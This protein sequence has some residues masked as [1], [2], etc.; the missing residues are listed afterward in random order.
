MPCSCSN[1]RRA[2]TRR[3]PRV[4]LAA[5]ATAA[6]ALLG[7]LSPTAASA[8]DLE[9]TRMLS[10][11]V[12]SAE[13][14]AFTYAGDLWIAKI[15]GFKVGPTR[16]LTSHIGREFNPR[17]SPD[18]K[19]L[20]FSAEY[21]GNID[22]Y[23]VPVE[24]GVPERLTWHPGPDITQGFRDDSKVLFTSP[25][26]D[27]SF[28]Y[29]HLYEIGLTGGFP[30][31]LPLPSVGFADMA[32]D[33]RIAYNPLGPA[34][35]QWKNYRGGQTSR[36]WIYQPDDASVSE[37][38]QPEGRANDTEP[39][40]LDGK[41]YLRSD[42]NGEFNLYR[43]DPQT[44]ALDQLT[45]HD[46]F[47][48]LGASAGGGRIVY[49]QAGYLHVLEPASG[50]AERLRVG[51][52]A[53]LIETRP[54]WA[55]GDEHI[56]SYALS[57][58]G[59]RAVFAYRGE[60]VTVPESKGNPRALTATPGAHER[61]PVWSPDGASIAYFSDASGEYALHVAPQD[62][63]GEPKAYELPGAGF[64][65]NPKFSP[66]GAYV[67]YLDNSW[68]VYIL[69]LESGESRK[70]AQEP[71]YGPL[72]TQHHAWS[73]D[74]R[75]LAYTLNTRSYFQ[76]VHLYS[77][78]NQK[79]HAI[80]EGLSDVSEPVFDAS[81]KYLYFA[82]STDAGPVRS[83]FAMSNADMEIT[84]SL[85]LAVLSADEPSPLL[86]ESDEETP[87][88][89][90]ESGEEEAEDDGGEESEDDDAIAVDIEGL[91]QRILALPLPESFYTN[92][93]PGSEGQ[94]LFLDSPE[95]IRGPGTGT[96]KRFD[97]ESRKAETLAE[98]VFGFVISHDHSKVL[99]A[100][101][102]GY[103]ISAAA[104][105]DLAKDK[106]HT[107]KIRVRI[108]PR[109]EWTQIF[110]EAWRINRDFFYD[111]GMHGADWPAMREKYAAFLPHLSSRDDLNR[112]IRWMCS[113]LAVG[114]HRV[115]GGDRRDS[116]E[117][118][119]GGVLGAD[120][121]IAQNRYRFAK[122]L[123]GLNWNPTLRAPLTEP[124]VDVRAGEFLL[125]VDGIP[126]EASENVYSRFENTAGR[127]V[128]L[129]VGPN[130]DGSDSRRVTVVPIQSDRGLRNRD[131]IEGNIR[132]VHEATDGRVAYVHVP[133][134]TTAGHAYFKRYFFPQANK[135]A[136]IVDERHN[137]G[138]QVADY[139]IDILRRPYISSWTTRYGEDLHTPQAAIHGPK[140][141]LID[142][143]AGSGGDLLPWMFRK[144]ELGTLIGRRT[145]G[146]LVGILGFPILMDGGGVTAP[147]LGFWTEDGF[148]VENEGVPPD[149]EVEQWPADVAAGRD[150]Q[151]EKAIEVVL[152]QLE[153][154]P[155]VERK[156]PPFPIRARQ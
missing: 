92:L 56:R 63:R 11:P 2:P 25:R 23:A 80:T 62:G 149:I 121:E 8:V 14:L 20:A 144:L 82:A 59:A 1:F 31:R 112:V 54:R 52:A 97:L 27:Y 156:R 3:G 103:A 107:D 153:A 134:T 71:V 129:T 57:P 24:G 122:V 43:F 88:A 28:R 95:G 151:L 51:V 9:D 130:A 99:A 75:W 84:Q 93:L 150:P 154:N 48:V 127:Q 91:D 124:G 15:D 16:R 139:Y 70:I 74:S 111:P 106:I 123:G 19:T 138:G 50:Q 133:N 83:W 49:R 147:N 101:P 67:S 132:K 42:R 155:P 78:E 141:M 58:S 37:I 29:F 36:V 146:G 46:D 76:Q 135:D 143:T 61:E 125:A 18:G 69:D 90:G 118:V 6:A 33:G 108:D 44:E 53:D 38:E 148:R 94:L 98:G 10:Q 47:P 140:V 89:D 128:E 137:G 126:L 68:S 77:L 136:I 39:F 86:A 45:F 64:Y 30:D 26:S 145:W 116:P 81:G 12:L 114:H 117:R 79:S 13:H 22:V 17:F 119:P 73:P 142:E 66:D 35:L 34:H 5:A 40:W 7:A 113:E 115:G 4:A 131:W 85:Y 87:S 72:R 32:S 104:K 21:D 102:Q 109:E 120:F 96:L 105:V 41:V 100:S 55:S 110:N 65:S 152:E 60:V